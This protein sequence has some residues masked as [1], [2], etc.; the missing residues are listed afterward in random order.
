MN[1]ARP[2]VGAEGLAAQVHAVRQAESAAVD[3]LQAAMDA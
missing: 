1:G 3:A 2:T